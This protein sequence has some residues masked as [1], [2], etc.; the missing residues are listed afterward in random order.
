[1]MDNIPLSSASLFA[2]LLDPGGGKATAFPHDWRLC[3]AAGCHNL[4]GTPM[5]EAFHRDTC[6]REV[7]D[8]STFGS[9]HDTRATYQKWPSAQGSSPPTLLLGR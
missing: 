2:D 1:M 3:K 7:Q 4:F 5:S 8:Q 9:G 6:T